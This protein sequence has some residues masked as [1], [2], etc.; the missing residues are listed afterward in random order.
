MSQDGK[1]HAPEPYPSVGQALHIPARD[2]PIPTT[3]SNEARAFVQATT[4]YPDMI[5]P[6]L[7]DRA[8]W[9]AHVAGID[10]QIM[11]LLEAITP[12]GTVEVTERFIGSVR[13]FDI[14]P[15]NLEGDPQALI[16]D[17]HGGGLILCAGEL[18][19]QMAT[20]T[21]LRYRRRV[22]SVDFRTAP[23]HPYPAALDDGVG[24]YDSLLR[25][26]RPDEIIFHGESG[27]GNLIAALLLRARDEGMP[28]PAGVILS[29]PQ[30]DLTE[31]G[32][33]FHANFGL[34]PGLKPLMPVHLLYAD[35]ADLRH[36]YLSPLFGDF[37]KGFPPTFLATGTRDLF[38]SNT[39]RMHQALR[40][41][42]IEA[43]L[44]VLEA[45]PHGNFPN[46]PESAE[47]DRLTRQ[48][49]EKVLAIK[50]A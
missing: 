4:V 34:D 39:V 16:L 29:T 3:V 5:Y 2:I 14:L 12:P 1:E 7:D 20:R 35:G 10:G 6:A 50:R 44:H 49:I 40:A 11:P 48:F 23:D 47:L 17:M 37:L 33:S 38:L 32:D 42:D 43:D 13:V 25:E 45:A 15:D 26:R 22:W 27:G 30:I 8:G 31:T 36:P 19:R 28:L 41:A 46:T 21:A 9:R 24:A 18:G